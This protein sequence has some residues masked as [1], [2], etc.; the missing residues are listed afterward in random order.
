MSSLF[1]K[2][3]EKTGCIQLSL[4]LIKKRSIYFFI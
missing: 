2:D 4:G 1:E 3:V